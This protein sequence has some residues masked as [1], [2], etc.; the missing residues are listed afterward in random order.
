LA[1]FQFCCIQPVSTGCL[2]VSNPRTKAVIG[3]D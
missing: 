2:N 1:V 3:C